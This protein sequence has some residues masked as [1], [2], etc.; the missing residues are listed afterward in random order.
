MKLGDND[1]MDE[2]SDKFENW[3]DPNVNPRVTSP[4]LLKKFLFDF[5][6]SLIFIQL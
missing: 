4:C 6:I 2:I 5:V 1:D 3:P